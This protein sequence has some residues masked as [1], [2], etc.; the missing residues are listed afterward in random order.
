M[1]Y[2]ITK[3]TRRNADEFNGVIPQ[4]VILRADDKGEPCM[5]ALIEDDNLLCFPLTTG[6]EIHLC[7]KY[8]QS[9][10]LGI[11]VEFKTYMQY[12]KMITKIDR[13][14]RKLNKRVP[15]KKERFYL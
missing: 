6:Y 13:K 7:N 11:T 9:L 5:Y 14:L 2:T 10:S 1:D 15:H 12:C 4:K 3:I 8:F